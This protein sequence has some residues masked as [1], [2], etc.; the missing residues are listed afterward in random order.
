[1]W[2]CHQDAADVVVVVGEE[3][4]V[5]EDLPP[6]VIPG[7]IFVSYTISKILKFHVLEHILCVILTY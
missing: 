5:A 7:V 6:H 2:K 4:E 3:E 1:V